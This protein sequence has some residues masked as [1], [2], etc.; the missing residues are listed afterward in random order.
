MACYHTLLLAMRDHTLQYR[1]RAVLAVL[2]EHMNSRSGM[3]WIG[4][5]RISEELG[6]AVETISNT[7]RDLTVS[8]YILAE[9][10]RTSETLNRSLRHYTLARLSR[11]EIEQKLSEAIANIKSSGPKKLS[12]F[13]GSS[14]VTA[15]SDFESHRQ[16]G[17]SLAANQRKSPPAV[18]E[19]HCGPWTVTNR[20]KLEG[21]SGAKDARRGV[22][23]RAKAH[24]FT[25]ENF[26]STDGDGRPAGKWELDAI[27][28]GRSKQFPEAQ[29]GEELFRFKNYH[30]AKGNRFA[31]WSAA[32]RTWLS[33]AAPAAGARIP[34]DQIA[35]RQ[36][37]AIL[38]GGR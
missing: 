5:G 23:G 6:L 20:R 25:S 38:R 19:S 21:E 9:N 10:R 8:G 7:L 4:R 13:L 2:I 31:D 12:T 35:S 11:E 16:S 37:D 14:R 33:R 27:E 15:D 3:T 34:A 18:D 26:F 29:I 1:H 30:Q 24:Q 28:Y 36:I 17:L 32:W 22:T